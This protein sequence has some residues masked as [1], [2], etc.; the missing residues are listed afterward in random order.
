[1]YT[2]WIFSDLKKAF[3]TVDHY[4]LLQKLD[5]I[6]GFKSIAFD[7][8]KSYL[9]NRQQYTKIGNKHSTKPNI[10]SGGPQGSSLGPS[11]IILYI[12]NLPSAS[13]ADDTLLSMADKNFDT[14]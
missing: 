5:I 1:M 13:D 3:D 9:T 6:Y 4:L 10:N 14:L 2:C 12:N 8:M 11:L 7:L